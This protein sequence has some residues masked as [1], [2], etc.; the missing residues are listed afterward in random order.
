MKTY[1]LT[2]AE[3]SSGVVRVDHLEVSCAKVRKGCD[4]FAE[5]IPSERAKPAENSLVPSYESF[6]QHEHSRVSFQPSIM[7]R[8]D[9]QNLAQVKVVIY[10]RS[11]INICNIV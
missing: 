9:L 8:I 6:E 10:M 7:E 5:N 3:R 11:G 4:V 2:V 1:L